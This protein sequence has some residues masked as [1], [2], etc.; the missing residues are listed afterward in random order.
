MEFI[1]ITTSGKAQLRYPLMSMIQLNP[2]SIRK[3]T[4]P[5]NSVQAGV[6]MRLTIGQ[7]PA[8]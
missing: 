8:A 3:Q 4:P 1:P 7:I 6:Q 2:A 5:L